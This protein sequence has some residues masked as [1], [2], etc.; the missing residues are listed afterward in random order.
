M[1]LPQSSCA[2][3]MSF[4][5]QASSSFIFIFSGPGYSA[6]PNSKVRRDWT[7]GGRLA[8]E[9]RLTMQERT[10]VRVESRG[11]VRG[12]GDGG[13]WMSGFRLGREVEGQEAVPEVRHVVGPPG[14]GSLANP[15]KLCWRIAYTPVLLHSSVCISV[16][17][18][19]YSFSMENDCFVMSAPTI[20]RKSKPRTMP[21]SAHV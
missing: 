4:L 12:V 3:P 16:N 6:S 13:A 18:W 7:G 15:V 5:A 20:T 11:D 2:V 14:Q 8:K 9:Q 10:H 21:K 17:A 1:T 19:I